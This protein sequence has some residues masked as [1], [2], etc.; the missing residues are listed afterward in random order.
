MTAGT[1]F[2]QLTETTTPLK[3]YSYWLKAWNRFR[4]NKLALFGISWALLTCFVALFAPWLTPY[5]YDGIDPA[6]ALQG[7]SA[8]HWLGLDNLGRDLAT[9]IMYATRPML[10]VG[11]VTQVVGLLIGVPLGLIAAYRGG[12]W[13]WIVTR[14]IDMFSA[15]PWYL[16]V[17]FMV[18]VLSPSLG[19]LMIAL[20]ITGWVGSC[21]L[22]RGMTF[23]VREREFINAAIALGIPQWR[24]LFRHVLPQVAPLIL[25]GFAAGIPTA[26]LA[27]ASLSFIG[28]GIRPPTPSWGRMLAE[29][30]Q[31][32]GYWPHMFFFPSI[33]ISLTILA[34]QGLADGLRDAL[35]VNVQ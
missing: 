21:R 2:I 26:V 3:Q 13:D 25:W 15:L 8:E 32:L 4:R 16:I 14:L 22:V 5:S 23:S 33:M 35:D 12:F 29:A 28:M 31:Y 10:L 19:N 11:V 30:G 20:I 9:R 1:T 6:N 34:F 27:E 18:M 17:L 24:I 7:P